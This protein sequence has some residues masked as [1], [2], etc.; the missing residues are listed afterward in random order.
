MTIPLA[1][2]LPDRGRRE[3]IQ[4]FYIQFVGEPS[5]GLQIRNLEIEY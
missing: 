3:K 5:A 1:E 2:I 4:D